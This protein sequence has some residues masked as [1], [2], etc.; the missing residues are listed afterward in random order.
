MRKVINKQ[1]AIIYSMPTMKEFISGAVCDDGCKKDCI[2]YAKEISD[3][4]FHTIS[5]H[6]N[7]E[8]LATFTYIQ[9]NCKNSCIM[10]VDSGNFCIFGNTRILNF[11]NPDTC[12]LRKKWT[13]A[14]RAA[15]TKGLE[16]IKKRDG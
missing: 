6:I 12:K 5:A 2:H 15:T 8:P 10:S 7:V 3:C 16:E 14:W 1:I 9:K 11:R 4:I 13:E